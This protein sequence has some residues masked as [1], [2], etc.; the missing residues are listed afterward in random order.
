MKCDKKGRG[1]EDD[2]CSEC[3]HF[4]GRCQRVEKQSY[5]DA[6]W[7]LMMKRSNGSNSESR[8]TLP[9]YDASMARGERK[10][11]KPAGKLHNVLDLGLKRLYR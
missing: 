3:R 9:E 5:N 8:Y 1:G 2:L 11:I 4:G 10:A 7:N 6:V